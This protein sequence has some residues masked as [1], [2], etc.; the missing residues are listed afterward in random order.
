[1]SWAD[2]KGHATY[3]AESPSESDSLV[4][5]VLCYFHATYY[6]EEEEESDRFHL[7]FSPIVTHTV[8]FKCIGTT[9]EDRYQETLVRVAQPRNAGQDVLCKLQ[10]EPENPFNSLA[11]VYVKQ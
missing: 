7:G 3:F 1:M 6:D 4:T 9:K 5:R 2:A 11:S 10:P 8:T